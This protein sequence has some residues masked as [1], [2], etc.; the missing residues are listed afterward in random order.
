MTK[1]KQPSLTTVPRKKA[2]Q[3]SAQFLIVA[4]AFY[5]GYVMGVDIP[6]GVEGAAVGAAGS[7][8]GYLVKERV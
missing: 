8:I 7:V 1:I 6:P 3:D 4:G 2:W 5:T